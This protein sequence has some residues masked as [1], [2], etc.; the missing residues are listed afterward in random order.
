MRWR[1]SHLH[2]LRSW[3]PASLAIILTLAVLVIAAIAGIAS[4][5]LVTAILSCV[6]LGV[7][8]HLAIQKN[9]APS[10]NSTIDKLIALAGD[11]KLS[12][13]HNDLLDNLLRV[14]Q[15]S[16]S[17]YRRL[18]LERLENSGLDVETLAKKVVDFE[19]TEC[20]RV[21]YEELLRSPGLHLYRSVSFIESQDYWQD[22]PGRQSTQLNLEL[23]KQ[24]VVTIERIAII[25]DHLWPQ[26]SLFPVSPIHSWLDIQHRHGIWLKLVRESALQNDPELIADIGIYGNRAVGKQVA[27]PSGRTI[28]FSL[29]FDFEELR[30]SE[31]IWERLVVYSTSYRELLDQQH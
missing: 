9:T 16:D 30:A 12:R 10:T 23:H 1:E 11:P 14:V 31:R 15:E 24:Q 27:D 3:L 5:Q 22:A 28:R 19:S 4:L 17:I 6:S 21:V 26:D 7:L 20:W 25:A 8:L 18:A 13:W 2:E 29:S